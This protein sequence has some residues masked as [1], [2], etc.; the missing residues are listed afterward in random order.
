MPASWSLNCIAQETD[1]TKETFSFPDD[2]KLTLVKV[3][4]FLNS[5][6]GVRWPAIEKALVYEVQLVELYA[7]GVL[8][9]SET[10]T[11]LGNTIKGL[12][13]NEDAGGFQPNFTLRIEGSSKGK[14]RVFSD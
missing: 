12:G 5:L 14:W 1:A 8:P 3:T 9:E 11:L 10:L 6:I 7:E 4:G 13:S 2:F